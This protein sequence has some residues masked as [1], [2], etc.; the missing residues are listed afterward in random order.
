M[1]GKMVIMVLF[2]L[3]FSASAM[4]ET[5]TY[6]SEA[7]RLLAAYPGPQGQALRNYAKA[8]A[9]RQGVDEKI[10]F[11]MLADHLYK[12]GYL[13]GQKDELKRKPT[14]KVDL[15]D[16][17]KQKEI[18]KTAKPEMNI[19]SAKNAYGFKNEELYVPPTH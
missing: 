13:P 18:K 9:A 11:I 4:A 12:K 5:W 3:L 16:L 1:K 8:E 2:F 19:I 17:H 7:C 10:F 15:A 6:K 14:L